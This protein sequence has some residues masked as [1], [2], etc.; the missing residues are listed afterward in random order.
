[1]KNTQTKK[2]SRNRRHARIRAKVVG[3]KE[4]P[5]LA[6]FKS[7]RYLYAQIID[8][9]ACNTICSGTTRDA[10][11]KDDIAELAK[12]IVTKAQDAGIVKVVFDR[13]GFIYTGKIKRFADALREAGLQF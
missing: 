5:R 6:V 9:T 1:M 11:T 8:D 10:K 12:D 7:N 2:E 3:T 13:G 4:V